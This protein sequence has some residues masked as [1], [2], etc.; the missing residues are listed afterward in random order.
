VPERRG[1][2]HDALSRGK[3]AIALVAEVFEGLTPHAT[4]FLRQLSSRACDPVFY[5]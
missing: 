4:R 5:V 2:Y 3:N 1:H